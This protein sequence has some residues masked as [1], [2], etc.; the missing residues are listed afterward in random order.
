M[1]LFI[2]TASDGNMIN[3]IPISK[4]LPTPF[5]PGDLPA[6]R[7]YEFLEMGMIV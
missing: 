6:D 4:G 7:E 3:L 1:I 5:V 2:S